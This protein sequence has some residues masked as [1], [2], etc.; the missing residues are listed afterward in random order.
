MLGHRKRDV[1]LWGTL[2][3]R[4]GIRPPRFWGRPGSGTGEATTR[5][6]RGPALKSFGDWRSENEKQQTT[7]ILNSN[8]FRHFFHDTRPAWNTAI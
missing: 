5:L 3:G 4:L 1:E 8:L 7:M 6:F 2:R